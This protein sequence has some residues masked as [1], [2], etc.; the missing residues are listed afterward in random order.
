MATARLSSALSSLID[1]IA[2][3]YS[4]LTARNRHG[5]WPKSNHGIL[6][7]SKW[8]NHPTLQRRIGMHLSIPQ[9]A[10]TSR[11]PRE[12]PSRY[13]SDMPIFPTPERLLS[14]LHSASHHDSNMIL[15]YL[16]SIFHIGNIT[17]ALKH[18]FLVSPDLSPS[19]LRLN[20]LSISGINS[21]IRNG[22]V[23]TYPCRPLWPSR[24]PWEL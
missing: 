14:P 6:F 9:N 8:P 4:F 7:T 24:S 16:L 13:L 11:Y 23:T 2:A 12:P 22:F 18:S 21:G 20:W 3:E 10:S 1:P 5:T 19:C 15:F 17:E